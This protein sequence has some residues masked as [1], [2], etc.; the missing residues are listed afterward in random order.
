MQD[1]GATS[2]APPPAA[3][4]G[5]SA[6]G[7]TSKPAAPLNSLPQTPGSST[8]ASDKVRGA[9]LQHKV[10]NMTASNHDA[11]ATATARA[12]AATAPLPAGVLYAGKYACS[13]SGGKYACSTWLLVLFDSLPTTLITARAPLPL[14]S[15][16][17]C[18]Q[19]GT[20]G[21][22]YADDAAHLPSL[23]HPLASQDVGPKGDQEAAA[24]EEAPAAV[25]AR[26]ATMERLAAQAP[27]VAPQVL[28][29]HAQ[30]LPTDTGSKHGA[31]LSPQQQE[32]DAPAGMAPDHVNADAG[33]EEAVQE[34]EVPTAPTPKVG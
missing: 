5:G 32:E 3:A 15:P 18:K 11:A 1:P 22:T 27:A 2:S 7:G 10:C 31:G 13:A 25:L 14:I 33:K 12:I 19:Y 34:Q 26:A 20:L 9:S 21:H 8:P 6:T 24:Q 23:L 17:H 4:A 30:Q 28:G 29:R 16:G